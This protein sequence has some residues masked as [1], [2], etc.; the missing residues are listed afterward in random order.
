V[1]DYGKIAPSFWT[2]HN[3]KLWKIPQIKGRLKPGKIPSHAALR[4]YVI[5]RDG[6]KCRGCGKSNNEA[7]L[8]ADHIISRRNGGSHHTDNLQCLCDSCNAKKANLID[9]NGVQNGEIQKG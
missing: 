8:V 5:M 3:G 6:K 7:R 2:D 4:D 9:S 1:R